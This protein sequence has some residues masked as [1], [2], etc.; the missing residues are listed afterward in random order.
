[1]S[2]LGSTAGRATSRTTLPP[3]AR[4]GLGPL[5]GIGARG[6]GARKV[7]STLTAVG[8]A[9]GIAAM[10]AVLG[11]SSSAS[12]TLLAALDSYGTNLLA[13]TPG[14]TLFGD[15]AT[16]PDAAAGMIARIGPVQAVS[17]VA[18]LDATVRRTDKVNRGET[19]GISVIAADPTLLG[20]LGGSMKLGRWLDAATDRYPAVVLGSVA[21]QR[22]GIVDLDAPIQV[23][24]ADRWFTVIGVLDP[25]PL[26][27]EI[28]RSAI[29]GLPFA[30]AVLKPGV[31]PSTIYVRAAPESIADVRS[32]LAATADPEH[33]EQVTVSRPSDLIEARATAATAFTGL[34]LGLG[35]VA[36]LVGG[37]GIV[38]VMLMT[39]LERRSEIGLRRALGATRGHI[40]GQF[41]VEAVALAALGGLVGVAVGS[42]IAVAYAN[43]Q[44]WT[45]DIPLATLLGGVGAALLVGAVSG[46]YPALRAASVPPTEALR[47]T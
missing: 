22:L 35:A 12:R 16:L 25:L 39:V 38:N 1:M 30:D 9:I 11:I 42:A 36:V 41:L 43:A 33:P 10:L 17:P 3:S 18:T 23:W 47:S 34:L 44:Q 26:S 6:I 14:K 15:G 40:A 29:V 5:L 21:A 8:I 7:R 13:V 32:V 31:T 45:V 2:A 19:G 37:L 4:L 24:I 27:P 20:T 28:E 46:L